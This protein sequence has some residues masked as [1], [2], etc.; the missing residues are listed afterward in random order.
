MSASIIRSTRINYNKFAI[1]FKT[2]IPCS[3]CKI[4]V[5]DT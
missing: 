4:T 1:T 3:L 5:E 2:F